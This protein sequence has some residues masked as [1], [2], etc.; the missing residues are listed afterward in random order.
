KDLTDLHRVVEARVFAT[1]TPNP[2]EAVTEVIGEVLGAT[3]EEAA[4]VGAVA[5]LNA[6]YAQVGS[7]L[8]IEH[9]AEGYRMATDKSMA[10]YLNVFFRQERKT[11]LSRSLMETLAIIAYCQPATKPEVD[12]VRGVDSDY[13]VRR[14]LE[15]G[16]IEITGR[17]ESLGKPLLYNTTLV[18]LERF[19]L[20]SLAELPT[21]RE[22]EELLNEPAFSKERAELLVLK[23]L[24]PPEATDSA[25]EATP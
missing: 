9:M 10:P 21:L 3:I 19:G 22:I 23:D 11:R 8:R 20:A 13:A 7:I 12:A 2:A 17:S 24:L 15:H 18:F 25:D 4:V 16:L 6:S 5:A 14:L 1:D